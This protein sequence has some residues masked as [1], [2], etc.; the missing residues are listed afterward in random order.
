MSHL[1]EKLQ[2]GEIVCGPFMKIPSPTIVEIFGM[3]GFDFVLFDMEHGP[4]DTESIED[5]IRAA[6]LAGT[7]PIARVSSNEA[8]L[9]SRVLDIGVEGLLVPQ[10][11]SR[12]EAENIVRGSLFSPE[13]ERGVCRYVRAA[14]YSHEDKKRYFER[15]NRETV[16]IALVEGVKGIDNIEDI[17]QVP[18][19]DVVFI[20]PYDLSQSLGVPGDIESDLVSGKMNEM[21]KKT[22]QAGL[23]VGTFVDNLTAAEKWVR[24]GIQF[25]AYAVD[26][27]I[28]YE[29]SKAIVDK[30][31][32]L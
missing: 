8:S 27:G 32:R 9:F 26:V 25:I 21:V 18:G 24:H 12:E 17:I 23:A 16:V 19:I 4:I 30:I 3:S 2:N 20:G 29:A 5:M 15:A 6:Q 13:G 10:V 28:I 11:S 22:R 7:S 31:K 1:K 14:S